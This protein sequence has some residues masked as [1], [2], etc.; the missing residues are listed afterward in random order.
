MPD[1]NTLEELAGYIDTHRDQVIEN[2]DPESIDVYVFLSRRFSEV[3]ISKDRL[4]RFVFRSF[5]RMDSA[6]LTDEFK[7]EYF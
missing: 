6:G 3:D 7:T 1:V 4:F 2:L 5:Y